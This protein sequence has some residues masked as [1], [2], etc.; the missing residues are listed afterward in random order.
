MKSQLIVM[1]LILA[2]F[3]VFASQILKPIKWT[4]EVSPAFKSKFFTMNRTVISLSDGVFLY[5]TSSGSQ[6]HMIDVDGIDKLFYQSTHDIRE[7]ILSEKKIWITLEDNKLYVI[8]ESARPSLKGGVS[9]TEV[10]LDASLEAI[11]PASQ[12]HLTT[13]SSNGVVLKVADGRDYRKATFFVGKTA[14]DFMNLRDDDFFVQS[15]MLMADASFTPNLK[16]YVSLEVGDATWIYKIQTVSNKGLS[17]AKILKLAGSSKDYG[18]FGM[19]TD[20]STVYLYR[21]NFDYTVHSVCVYEI[22]FTAAAGS[23]S[24]KCKDDKALFGDEGFNGFCGLNQSGSSYFICK[25]ILNPSE[26]PKGSVDDDT[27]IY[28]KEVIMYKIQK[29]ASLKKIGHGNMLTDDETKDVSYNDFKNSQRLEHF[30]GESQIIEMGDGVSIN[31]AL[32]DSVSYVY[33]HDSAFMSAVSAAIVFVIAVLGL[34]II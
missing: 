10:K 1:L 17:A 5:V 9:L 31:Y 34:A 3:G 13:A 20:M 7:M 21:G 11:Y 2:S 12:F 16:H 23:L 22:N 19:S 26:Y 8:H 24:G 15:D 14:I 32:K 27:D 30:D 29:D 18:H 28:F 6:I 4:G 33:M 25:S